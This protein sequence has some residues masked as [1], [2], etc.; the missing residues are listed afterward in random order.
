MND[1]SVF[2][3]SRLFEFIE[4]LKENVYHLIGD[5]GFPLLEWLLRPYNETPKFGLQ[6]RYFNYRLSRARMVVENAFGILKGTFK[7]RFKETFY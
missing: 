4:N 7:S 1:A 6:K 3:R 5:G 2:R